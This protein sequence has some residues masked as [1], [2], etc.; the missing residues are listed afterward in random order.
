V[1]YLLVLGLLL[2]GLKGFAETSSLNLNIPNTSRNFQQDQVRAGNVHC[3]H[4]IG[5]AT[6]VE[7]GVVGILNQS[8]PYRY[9]ESPEHYDDSLVKDV[10]VY[11]KINIPIGAP[12]ERLN[13][14]L[15][16][17]L[18]IEKKELELQKLRQEV[19]NLKQLQFEN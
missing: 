4:A 19:A 18:E 13:C 15:L 7:F 17:K 2:Y 9:V 11:A 5:A 6:N 12:K 14:N 3:S 8:D 1:R 16:Y 10:G